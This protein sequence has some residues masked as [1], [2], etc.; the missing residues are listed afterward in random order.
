[1]P[2]PFL[3]TW[4]AP[5]SLFRGHFMMPPPLPCFHNVLGVPP[6]LVYVLYLLYCLP[7][8]LTELRES[9]DGLF[10]LFLFMLCTEHSIVRVERGN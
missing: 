7:P 1:M 9:T 8:H 5:L 4:P 10:H 2:A 6:R 3:I